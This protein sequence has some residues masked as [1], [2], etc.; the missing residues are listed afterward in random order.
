[1]STPPATNKANRSTPSMLGLL[2]VLV[3]ALVVVGIYMEILGRKAYDNTQRAT[4][5]LLNERGINS[6]LIDMETGTRGYVITGDPQFLQPY[7]DARS[8]LPGL[9][10]QL[11]VG[12]ALL[13]SENAA[14]KAQLD[15]MVTATKNA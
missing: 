3:A 6:F 12:I 2:I 11:G 4:D 14:G 7:N 13:D 8:Q 15:R 5:L 1:M 9:W 10:A